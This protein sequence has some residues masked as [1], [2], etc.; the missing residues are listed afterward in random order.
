METNVS[1]Q[2]LTRTS[3]ISESPD[4]VEMANFRIETAGLDKSTDVVNT[5][6][7]LVDT[8]DLN[9]LKTW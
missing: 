9:N 5:T 6:T 2:G 1:A 4:K 3:V 7:I 8:I